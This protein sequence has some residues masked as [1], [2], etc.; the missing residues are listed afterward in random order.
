M[1]NIPLTHWT[2]SRKYRLE[3]DKAFYTSGSESTDSEVAAELIAEKVQ[4]IIHGEF[5]EMNSMDN[6]EHS[7]GHHTASWSKDLNLLHDKAEDEIFGDMSVSDFD[8]RVIARQRITQLK[9][10]LAEAEQLLRQHS[11]PFDKR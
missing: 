1:E 10:R 9:E 11:I 6:K 3:S 2:A 7:L 8:I 5:V 4:N